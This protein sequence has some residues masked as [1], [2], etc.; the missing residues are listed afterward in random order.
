MARLRLVVPI[1]VALLA[2]AFVAWWGLTGFAWSDYDNEAAGPLV[3][4]TGGHLDAFFSSAPA[5]GGS[6]LL[7]SPFA[8]VTAFSGGGET[9]VYR[10]MALPCLLAVVGVGVVLFKLRTD[11]LPRARWSLLVVVLAAGNPVFLSALDVG[12]PEEL[13]G[14]ALCVGAVLAA[15]FKRPWLAGLLLGLALAN[16]AWAVLAIG[17]VLVALDRHRLGALGLAGT[18]AAVLV[19]PFLVGSGAATGAVH[20]AGT[21]NTIF[22]PWQVWWP[23]GDL[24]HVVRG[25]DGAVKPGYRVP[26]Q[27]LGSVSHPLIA[28]SGVPLSL[29]WL[30]R[31]RGDRTPDVLLLLALVLL[32]RCVLDPWNTGYY[33]VP[34]L[35]A[36]LA[37]E[38]LQ[39]ERPPI[40][41][42]T[43]A[44][45]VW[46]SFEK[47]PQLVGPDA[48]SALYL[49]WAVPAVLALAWA[50]FRLPVPVRHPRAVAPRPT[51]RSPSA[52]APD[53]AHP[54]AHPHYLSALGAP[55]HP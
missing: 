38:A 26:P 17:P 1:A 51:N 7:R 43:A 24:G 12:H 44:A 37:W 23:L 54:P 10:V 6:L 22:Q 53:A 27:W 49:A 48:Q 13:L 15:S 40:L 14:A 46:L 21:T 30:R 33:H 32:V 28:V 4:L 34:F 5:Y 19:A 36:L 25:L 16:K 35:L 3:A 42:L 8:L 20:A 50:A 41:S 55:E 45:L 2:A 31:R 39:R 9:A 47:L 18:I 52:G 11:R 29:L